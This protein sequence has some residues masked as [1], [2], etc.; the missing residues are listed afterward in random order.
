[1]P[2][3]PMR[4]P[5]PRHHRNVRV[6]RGADPPRAARQHLTRDARNRPLPR[7]VVPGVRDRFSERGRSRTQRGGQGLPSL[8]AVRRRSSSRT[9]C[10]SSRRRSARS[11]TTRGSSRSRS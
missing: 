9:S 8:R 5:P 7:S 3:R 11:A 4:R 10:S 2:R 1:M 6:P